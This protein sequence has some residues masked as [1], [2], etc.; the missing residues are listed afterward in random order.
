MTRETAKNGTEIEFAAEFTKKCADICS[1]F[2][3]SARCLTGLL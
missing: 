1:D 3:M 2:S